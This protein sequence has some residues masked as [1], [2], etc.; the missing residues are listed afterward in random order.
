MGKTKIILLIIALILISGCSIQLK[1]NNQN[2][3]DLGVYKTNNKGDSWV[4]RTLVPTI[5]GN[6]NIGSINAEKLVMDPSDN[7]AI[8]WASSQG[9]FYTYDG[10]NGW[11]VAIS[12]GQIAVNDIAIDYNAKCVIYV[13]SGNKVYK[14]TDCNRGWTQ[15]YFDN[16]ISLKIKAI[17]VDHY[18]GKNVYLGTSRGEIIKSSDSGTSWQ[19]IKRFDRDVEKII[20]S[21]LD[22]RVIF[23]VT[24]GGIIFRTQDSGNS[25]DNLREKSDELKNMKAF[26]DLVAVGDEK[27]TLLLVT[28]SEL[29]KSTDDGESWE[30]IKLITPPKEGTINSAAVSP[31]NTSE[32]YYI[33]NTTYF[34][35]FDGGENWATKKLPTNGAGWKLLINP[36]DPKIIYMGVRKK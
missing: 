32:I 8:Y 10:A 30:K 11:Q 26:K 13:S 22:S 16:N 36:V 27:N 14:S 5:S 7:K 6:Q 9:L 18:D 33:T 23:A 25:W 35:S 12:L 31:K 21:P 28:V 4:Q 34:R 19:T 2:L 15:V 20:M 24:E 1:T 3:N 29:L 17:I